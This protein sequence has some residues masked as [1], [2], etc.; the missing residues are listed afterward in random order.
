MQLKCLYPKRR[1]KA[2][3]VMRCDAGSIVPHKIFSKLRA[4][5]TSKHCHLVCSNHLHTCELWR[6]IVRLDPFFPDTCVG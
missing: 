4:F 6:I 5:A 2:H 3:R 1:R